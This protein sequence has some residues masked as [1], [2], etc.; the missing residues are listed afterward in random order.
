MSIF[1]R[2]GGRLGTRGESWDVQIASLLVF[3]LPRRQAEEWLGDLRESRRALRDLGWPEWVLALVTI[4]RT[5]LLVWSLV[6]IKYEDIRPG[7]GGLTEESQAL[8]KIRHVIEKAALSRAHVVITGGTV[9]ETKAIARKMH[10]L[11]P[12]RTRPFISVNC[13]DSEEVVESTIF[14]RPFWKT[15]SPSFRSDAG[16][17]FFYNAE[18]LSLRTQLK[19][20]RAAQERSEVRLIASSPDDLAM[21][22]YE[23]KFREDLYFRLNAIRIPLPRQDD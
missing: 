16:T 7:T 3:V 8:T 12:W 1:V 22:V 4:G 11:G 19:I 18:R 13:D 15:E 10:N 21:A 23:G 20:L 14:A 2:G 17:I 6:R 5:A 9:R